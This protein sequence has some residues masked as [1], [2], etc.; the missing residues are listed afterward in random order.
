MHRGAHRRSTLSSLLPIPRGLND[1][2]IVGW[3]LLADIVGWALL[4][5]IVGWAL[6]AD[7]V[8][9]ASLAGHRWLGIV[10]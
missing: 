4:A 5:D 1:S 10:G 3:G 2:P 9:W 8:G 6:L 7:I